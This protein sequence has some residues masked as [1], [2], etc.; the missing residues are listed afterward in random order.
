MALPPPRAA[1]F[2]KMRAEA[3]RRSNLRSFNSYVKLTAHEGTSTV[4][5]GTQMDHRMLPIDGRWGYCRLG[6]VLVVAHPDVSVFASAFSQS[7]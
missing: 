4:E 5:V 7:G 3:D 2:P 1:L 6:V